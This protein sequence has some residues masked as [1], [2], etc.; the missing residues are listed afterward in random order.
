MCNFPESHPKMSR[1]FF[2]LA[3]LAAALSCGVGSGAYGQST[4][5]VT[6]SDMTYLGSFHVPV[7]SG[8]GFSYGGYGLAFNPAR[9]S[10]YLSGHVYD[11]YTAELSIPALGGTATIL[12]PLTDA[13]G[14]KLPQ[15]G[16]GTARVGGNLVYNNKLYMTGF[17]YYDGSG[18][19]TLSHFNRPLDLSATGVAGP[20]RVGSDGAGY[21]SGYM[22]TIPSD[23]QAKLGAPA[24]TGNCCL[25]IISRTSYG[26]SISAWDPQNTA[27]NAQMLVGYDQSHQTLGTYGASGSNPVFNGTTRITGVFFPPGTGSVLFFGS[28]GVGNYCYGEA[29]SCNDPTTNSK[30]EHAYPYAAYIWAYNANDLAAVRAGTKQPYEVTPYATWQLTDFGNVGYDFATGGAAFDPATGKVYFSQTG[31]DGDR[32]LIRVYKVTSSTVTTPPAATPN[33]PTNVKVQ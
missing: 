12:Q 7:V 3:L 20:Y 2:S 24:M 23:W 9:N 28:T 17:L 27:V 32:P 4:T 18:S 30:G 11:L 14:G 25:S 6:K 22:T 19:Q 8:N 5:L 15:I 29:S 21:Y 1:N 26:P 33:P 31:A 16:S 13:Y 10:L